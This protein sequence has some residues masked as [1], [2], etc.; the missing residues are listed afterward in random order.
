MSKQPR[1]QTIPRIVSIVVLGSRDE[2]SLLAMAASLALAVDDR[3]GDAIRKTAPGS[4]ALLHVEQIQFTSKRGVAGSIDGH[5]VILGNSSFLTDLG[6]SI[7]S[8]GHW[9]ERLAHQRQRITFL[10]VD[11]ELAAFFK[12]SA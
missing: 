8:L 12:L 1:L 11:G 2:S 9:A 5:V 7:G 4:A 3:L 10:A 6:V